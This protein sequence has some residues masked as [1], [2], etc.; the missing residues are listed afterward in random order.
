M[1]KVESQNDYGEIVI[2]WSHHCEIWGEI[3]GDT[4]TTRYLPDVLPGW[5]VAIARGRM[6]Y[7]IVGVVDRP[8]RTRLVE[9]R[10][11]EVSSRGE[12][13][14]GATAMNSNRQG[15]SPEQS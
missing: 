3:H 10:L 9:L 4:V 12:N 2:E 5:R 14:R 13:N 11:E 8:G 7:T 6:M 15:L 1:K